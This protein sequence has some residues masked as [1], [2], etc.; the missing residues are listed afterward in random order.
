MKC[1][2][3]V[4]F[5]GDKQQ[6]PL[7]SGL[8]R[9]EF[10]WQRLWVDG[11]RVPTGGE[12]AGWPGLRAACAGLSWLCLCFPTHLKE[13]GMCSLPH[14]E[15]PAIPVHQGITKALFCGG[16]CCKR[17]AVIVPPWLSPSGCEQPVEHRCGCVH[18]S[19]HP[20]HPCLYLGVSTTNI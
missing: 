7:A 16:V 4:A 17:S 6:L 8:Q 5:R 1:A 11:R 3:P 18:I 2:Q 9:V 15:A 19:T 10:P 14:W 12:G 13:A 20:T